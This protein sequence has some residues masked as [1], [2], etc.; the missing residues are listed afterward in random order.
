MDQMDGMV[1][2]AYM[3]YK[4]GARKCD[5]MEEKISMPHG[6]RQDGEGSQGKGIC[7]AAGGFLAVTK[8]G[9]REVRM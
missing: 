2:Q 4:S 3:T 9:K 7:D 5:R 8:D 1:R 6:R